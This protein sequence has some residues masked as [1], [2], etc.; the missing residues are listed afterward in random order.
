MV[1]LGGG[2]V[3]YERGTPMLEPF[4]GK[5]MEPLMRTLEPLDEDSG[6]IDLED[7]NEG[8]GAI[9]GRAS[10]PL[11]RKTLEPLDEGI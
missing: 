1:V 5:T 11:I 10:E 3:S 4:L 6:A 8:T 9:F 7:L 2:A